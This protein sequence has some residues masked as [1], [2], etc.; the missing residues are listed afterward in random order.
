MEQHVK[1]HQD[2]DLA[3]D[4]VAAVEQVG[5]GDQ[6]GQIGVGGAQGLLVVGNEYDAALVLFK[7]RQD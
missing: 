1:E 6:Q 4:G 2:Q 3:G 7:I 5:L